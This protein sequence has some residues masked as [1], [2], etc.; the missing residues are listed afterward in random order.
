MSTDEIVAAIEKIVAQMDTLNDS[1]KRLIG[2]DN[3]N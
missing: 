3:A 2:D 1:M